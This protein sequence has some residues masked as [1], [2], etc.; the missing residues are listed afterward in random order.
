MSQATVNL[1][2]PAPFVRLLRISLFCVFARAFLGF[3]RRTHP[4]LFVLFTVGLSGSMRP[5][6]VHPLV[7]LSNL[8]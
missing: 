2:V 7:V 4:F 3:D 6:T 8:L 1:L 5:V